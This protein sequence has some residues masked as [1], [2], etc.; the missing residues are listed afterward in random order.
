VP[1]VQPT[2]SEAT[3]RRLLT[4]GTSQLAKF[5]SLEAATALLLLVLACAANVHPAFGECQ[6]RRLAH[7]ASATINTRSSASGGLT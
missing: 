4:W 1:R 7:L 6:E 3:F 2:G 5:P